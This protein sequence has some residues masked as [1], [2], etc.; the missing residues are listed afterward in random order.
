M[1]MTCIMCQIKSLFSAL[2]F[3]CFSC[4][5]AS[6]NVTDDIIFDFKWLGNSKQPGEKSDVVK[7]R[8]IIGEDYECVIPTLFHNIEENEA[9]NSDSVDEETL[10][11]P[12]FTEQP[13]NVRSEA[14]WSYELCHNR[15][16]KQ[17]H[18][19]KKLEKNPPV[20]EFYLGHYYPDPK[21]K[22]ERPSKDN[23]PKTV[24]LGEHSYP[25]YGISYVDGTLCD[26]NQEHRTATVMYICHE[27]VTGQI[28]DVSEIR[29]CQYQMVFA[30]KFLCSNPLYKQK[31]AH[32]NPISCHSKN[33]SPSKPSALVAMEAERKKF[34]SRSFTDLA[35]ILSNAF[36]SKVKISAKHGKDV[37]FYQVNPAEDPN[38]ESTSTI[39]NT[40]INVNDD[41][42]NSHDSS[43][44]S[45]LDFVN[46][47]ASSLKTPS[48]LTSST[49]NPSIMKS[50]DDN[51]VM[52]FL[53]G[54]LCLTGNL[55]WWT[56][57]ICFN[58]F[59]RQYHL[60]ANTK[61]LQEIRL[62]NWDLD[63]HVK[64]FEENNLKK[65]KSSGSS[66]RQ[67]SLYY[68][69]GDLCTET[70]KLREVVVK[71]KCLHSTSKDIFLSFSEP[72]KCVYSMSVESAMFC[73]L[74]PLANENDILPLDKV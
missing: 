18:E 12:L 55:G 23:P 71:I 41:T 57:E 36:K 4:V 56:Y 10:L 69:R 43:S 2:E 67:I 53:Q 26:L 45:D 68:G 16:I 38:D 21:M 32:T 64:W 47:V 27:S 17:F 29:T 3:L 61:Q 44:F 58:K 65:Q 42:K 15:Y 49:I 70:N 66:N 54:K 20:Q 14:Y 13:C 22:K 52:E 25:Y 30:T 19:E 39:D 33:S 37:V 35:A 31:R 74:I 1:Q 24:T 73:D 34:Q 62:G 28:V 8:T 59:V 6:Y 9:K 48:S 5:I 7:I 72:T 46:Q 60:D 11:Q 63:N 50:V 40:Q 51:Q